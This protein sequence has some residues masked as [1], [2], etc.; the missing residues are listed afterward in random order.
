MQLQG[1][2]ISL[3]LLLV[4][5][6]TWEP[7]L[8]GRDSLFQGQ[9][10]GEVN[11]DYVTVQICLGL[12]VSLLPSQSAG[13]IP[14]PRGGSRGKQSSKARGGQHK[15]FATQ[16]RLRAGAAAA[17]AGWSSAWLQLSSPCSPQVAGERY[18]YKFVCEPQALFSLACPEQRPAPRAEPDPQVSE[19]DTVPLSHLDQSATYQLDP[20]SLPQLYSKGYRY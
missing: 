3:D 10:S 11:C 8:C 15:K 19:E 4:R 12:L 7:A 1:H 6:A 5:K 14:F 13:S 9:G 2:T 17:P 20:G 16:T 18:V